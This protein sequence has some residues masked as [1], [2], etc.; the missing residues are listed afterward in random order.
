MTSAVESR[1]PVLVTGI[2]GGGHGEQILKALKLA[3]RYFIVGADAIGECANRHEVAHF[4]LLPRAHDPRYLGELVALAE[5]FSCRAIFHGSEAEMMV[6]SHERER[7]AE[8]GFYVPVNP[9]S[10]MRICQDKSATMAF[11]AAQGAR[12]P[13]FRE[14]RSLAD[15]SDF[16]DFPAVI[17]PSRGGGG[18]ANVFIV[19]NSEELHLFSTYLLGM[20]E[21]FV[22]QEYVGTPDQEYT[23]GVLFSADGELLNSIA[24]R[25]VINNALTIR[26]SVPNRTGRSELGSRLVISTGISQGYVGDWPELL[27]QC[28]HIASALKPRAPINIQCRLVDGLVVPF[29]INPRFSGTTSL[30]ALAGYNEPD[31]LFRRDVLGERIA[32][33]F[34]Y[35]KGLILRS[36][37]ENLISS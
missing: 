32:T 2:G 31:A 23:V 17:K 37:K 36:L 15:C 16:R 6:L 11:L 5:R 22:L 8:R 13:A 33:H 24:I 10:V 3:D 7:L 25:R 20:Y 30:R 18:S 35:Q 34:P 14:V 28:E 21:G 27:R 26:T 4:S 19:Q 29:E 9:P 1:H 12:V